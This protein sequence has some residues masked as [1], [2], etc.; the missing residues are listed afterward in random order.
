MCTRNPRRRGE[1]G[2]PSIGTPR[3]CSCDSC[4][5]RSP[6]YFRPTQNYNSFHHF[7]LISAIGQWNNQPCERM[8]AVCHSHR[9]IVPV[10][11]SGIGMYYGSVTCNHL[12]VWTYC[13]Q[14]YVQ[15][16]PCSS[17]TLT[18]GGSIARRASA[19]MPTH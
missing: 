4:A 8:D 12:H 10:W 15:Y 5:R 18:C 19:R 16:V 11:V 17:T 9:W 13:T 14:T 2:K 7:L 3:P 1:Q 6:P